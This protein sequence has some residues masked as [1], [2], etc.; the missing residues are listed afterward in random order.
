MVHFVVNICL[1]LLL[2]AKAFREEDWEYNYKQEHDCFRIQVFLSF[3]H[4][5]VWQIHFAITI[6]P[7]ALYARQ[8]ELVVSW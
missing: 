8:V 4:S 6:L 3:S 2:F 7:C 5:L 1:I